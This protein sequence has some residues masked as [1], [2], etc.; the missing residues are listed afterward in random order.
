MKSHRVWLVLIVASLVV[1]GA[2]RPSSRAQD[3]PKLEPMLKSPPGP[4]LNVGRGRIP[5]E[6]AL[7]KPMTLPFAE[8]TSLQDVARTLQD[9]LGAPVVLDLAALARLDLTPEST[10][11]LHLEGVR[12][13]TGLKL[14]LDQVGLTYKVL[15]GD[16]LLLLTDEVGTEDPSARIFAELQAIRRDLDG[17]KHLVDD[18]NESLT[19]IEEI[20][21]EIRRPTIIEEMPAEKG[22]EPDDAAPGRSRPG[23]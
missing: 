18:L 9:Q 14:L 2:W 11:K 6:E 7:V 1:A 10:V 5:I 13:M 4:F 23:L 3:E 22:H 17:L 12:L 16:N 21:P 20:G 8:E 15:A 19:P